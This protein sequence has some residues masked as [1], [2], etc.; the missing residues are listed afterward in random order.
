[1]EE[2][3]NL[4][5]FKRF[6]QESPKDK[7]EF[8]FCPKCS[9]DIE[10]LSIDETK[11]N[12]EINLFMK[13]RCLKE[14]L[15][16]NISFNEFIR[17]MKEKKIEKIEK[18]NDE[19]GKHSS[20]K[21][22]SYCFDCNNHLC[23]DC[24]KSGA[25]LKHVKNNIIEVK[26]LEEEL[27][28]VREVINDYK[29]KLEE[30]KK[31]KEEKKKEYNKLMNH[32]KI[33]L[34]RE[35]DNI[36][37]KNNNKKIIELE[38]NKKKY[39]MDIDKLKKEFE[40]KIRKRKIEYLEEKNQIYNKYKLITQKYI[41]NHKNK[42]NELINNYEKEIN[43]YKFEKKIENYENMIKINK[44]I[45]EKYYNYNNNYYN[46]ININS[47]LIYYTNNN[48][49]NDKIMKVKLKDKYDFILN[50]INNRKGKI[51]LKIDEL[52]NEYEERI[53]IIEEQHKNEINKLKNEV[54]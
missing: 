12:E 38:N 34:E 18:L 37:E 24:L 35:L 5:N 48:Y 15:V 7:L 31:E 22:I 9:S 50:I 11:T 49:I 27:D 4:I 2:E 51:H 41:I 29:I 14:N 10:I 28:I 21:F 42:I 17:L 16:N 30:T 1:M 23:E 52:K 36:R 47:L 53:K 19:C 26:P 44:N 8:L 43:K 20:K 32:D 54:S 33:K 46:S 40:N 39:I 6:V 3:N 25:H 45:Y 13:Y